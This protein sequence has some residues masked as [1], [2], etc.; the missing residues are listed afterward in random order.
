MKKKLVS[1]LKIHRKPNSNKKDDLE[2]GDSNDRL[3]ILE[4]PV[5][6]LTS[7][8]GEL[9]EQLCLT[10]LVKASA[11]AKRR[12]RSKKKGVMEVDGDDDFA[13]NDSDSMFMK[14]TRGLSESIRRELKLFTVANI[15]DA[16]MKAIAIEGKYL[17]SDKEDDKIKS[18]YKSSWKN[19]HKGEAKG[20]G[21]SSNEFYCN[22]C[23]YKCGGCVVRFGDSK[24]VCDDDDERS[25]IIWAWEK[26]PLLTTFIQTQSLRP[27]LEIFIGT[28]V[29]SSNPDVYKKEGLSR[30]VPEGEINADEK[31]NFFDIVAPIG[32]TNTLQNNKT[33]INK[34]ASGLKQKECNYA[35]GKW[36]EDNRRPLYSGFG[37][38]QWLSEMWACR[39][40]QRLDFSYERFRWQPNNCE[41]P[42][43]EVL[44]FLKRMQNKTIALVGDS[45][46]RQQFQSLMCM[47]TGGEWMADV[48]DVGKEYDLVKA[49]GAIRPDG[50]AYRFT[51][52]N[53]T[54]LY[55]WSASL[56]DLEP[57]NI[58]NPA[59]DWA[60]HLDR[61]PSFLTRYIHRFDVLIL[62]T[63]HHWNRGKLQANRWVMHVGGVRNTNRKIA[64]IGGAKNFTI[65]SVI[66]WLIRSF[67]NIL[68]SK[69]SLGPYRPDISSMGIGIQG[70]AA[71]IR[72]LCRVEMKLC[73][74]SPMTLLL[75]VL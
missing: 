30:V 43:F 11:S 27:S 75:Q 63:G 6:A 60:M 65:Y 49:R 66:K 35:K 37:C 36:V 39:L 47:A 71:I 10:N 61:P 48:I 44:S 72:L 41:M 68:G 62:N 31:G 13:K 8:I 38:K 42:E 9:V 4:T 14:Y 23:K 5:S 15:E 64:E 57:L 52:T 16:T 45:L 56:C 59:T 54:I 67:R 18:G 73:K 69:P 2:M 40:T 32:T 51:T 34:K 1:L 12:D 22:H 25:I 46:G 50:W 74:T 3:T 70:E 53:T 24:V 7:T 28:P 29:V 58:T 21:P 19:E 26:N 17:K 33:E 55:Y 20:E